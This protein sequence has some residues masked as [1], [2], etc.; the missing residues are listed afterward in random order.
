MVYDLLGAE[1]RTLVSRREDAGQHSVSFDART[2]PSGVYFYRLQVG[3]FAET[4]K[5]LLIR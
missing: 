1:V 3:G 2:F 4:K 5:M